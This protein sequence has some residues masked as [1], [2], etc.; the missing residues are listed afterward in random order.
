MSQKYKKIVTQLPVNCVCHGPAPTCCFSIYEQI[1]N[2]SRSVAFVRC[3][4]GQPGA[5]DL[6]LAAAGCH[7]RLSR[8]PPAGSLHKFYFRV[9]SELLDEPIR[10]DDPGHFWDKP[11]RLDVQSSLEPDEVYLHIN[12]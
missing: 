9:W 12:Y 6:T 10:C 1:A 7:F 8:G 5:T 4:V 3:S 2:R 11:S